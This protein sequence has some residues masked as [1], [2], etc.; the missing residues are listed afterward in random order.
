MSNHSKY[1]IK[2]NSSLDKTLEPHC[3]GILISDQYVLSAAHCI[4]KIPPVIK[5][6]YIVLGEWNRTLSEIGCQ[7]ID[8]NLCPPSPVQI[9]VLKVNVHENYKPNSRD[10]NDDIALIKLGR[11]VELS[12]YIKPVCLPSHEDIIN[13]GLEF[14][15]FNAAGWGK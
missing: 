12:N 14:E 1:Y 10:Q 15:I 9:R 8:K 6:K 13:K 7:E 4:L 11:K 2:N 3:G 5:L